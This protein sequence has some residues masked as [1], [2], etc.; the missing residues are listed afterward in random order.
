M[1]SSQDFILTHSCSELCFSMPGFPVVGGL[2]WDPPPHYLKNWLAPPPPPPP[3]VLTQKCRFCYFHAVFGHFAQIPPHQLTPFGKPC[4]LVLL[5]ILLLT[6]DVS[7]V[8]L[9]L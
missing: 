8:G 6:C 9:R 1:R 4:M 3:T 5:M 2:E 7:V